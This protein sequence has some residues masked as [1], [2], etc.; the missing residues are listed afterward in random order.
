MILTINHVDVTLVV[1]GYIFRVHKRTTLPKTAPFSHVRQRRVREIRT[2][3]GIGLMDNSDAA[4]LLRS[5][6]GFAKRLRVG[7]DDCGHQ[8]CQE[9]QDSQTSERFEVSRCCVALHGHAS[10]LGRLTCQR[11][12]NGSHERV[13]RCGCGWTGRR[14]Q[15]GS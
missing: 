1:D 9:K 15:C 5:S 4:G 8:A 6:V 12:T 13:R 3:S 11:C 10:M 14:S 7:I 2:I